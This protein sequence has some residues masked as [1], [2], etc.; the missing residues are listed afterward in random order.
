[1]ECVQVGETPELDLL[2]RQLQHRVNI[3]LRTQDALARLAGMLEPILATA[4][5][6]GLILA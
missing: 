1:M 2:L 3:E 5:V 4:A 6:S